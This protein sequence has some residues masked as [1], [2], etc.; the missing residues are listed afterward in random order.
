MIDSIQTATVDD[1]DGAAGSV[2]QVRESTLRLMDLAKG[3]G[4]AVIL[5]GHVTKDGSIAGPKTLEHLVDA[6][7]NLEGERYAALRLLRA[8]KNRFGSTD[9]I[10]V[11]EMAESGLLE[12]A[13]PARAFLADHGGSA[14]GSVVA[15]TL[16][17]SRPLLVEVQA[18]VSPTGYGTPSRKASGLDPNRLSLLIAVLGRRAGIALGS[19]DV[20]A[21]LAGGLSVA[22]P[23][24]DLPLALALASSARDR[25]IPPGAWRSE[26]SVSWGSCGSSSG[27]SGDCARPPDSASGCD[28]A[29]PR[30]RCNAAQDRGARGL[31][32]GHASGRHRDR[33]VRSPDA[34]WRGAPRDA[35]LTVRRGRSRPGT[36]KLPRELLIRYI[37]VLGAALG[38]AIGLALATS[39]GGLFSGS[40]YAGAFL[41]AWVVAWIVVGFAIL[42]YLTVVPATWLIRRVEELST[43]EFVAAVIGLLLGLLMGL[44]LGVPLSGLEGPVGTWLPLGIS[45]FMGL[46]MLGLTVAKRKDLLIA[47]EAVGILRP[48]NTDR[49]YGLARGEPRIVVDTSAIIDGRIAEIVESGFIYGTLVIPRFVLDELQHIADSSDA[50]RRNRGRRGLDILNRM[51]KEPG[52]PVE[53]VEDDVPEIAEVDAKLVALALARS[54]VILTNDFNLNRVAELQGVRVMNINSLANAVKPAV[55]PGEELRVRVIQEG[56]EAGQGVAFLDDGTMIVIEGGAR[57]IDRDLDVSVT[58]VLQTVA[59]RMIFAQP[60]LD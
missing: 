55:L 51:Q 52:T 26:R 46:G 21:N 56:K 33:P 42:P 22:E 18:L 34:S 1:L 40:A 32:R 31:P 12:V 48:P 35:R 36:P 11:F 53:I 59:G 57:H 17:G 14:P 8:T 29:T 20:Y 25:A 43:A 16:E 19:H 45:I 37:R 23:A 49:A 7:I 24:L 6:V 38:G 41:A 50:L 44:L 9:E 4:I 28:R 3:D 15:P 60:R 27:S 47:A 39:G 54:R 10:G 5:V 2:G 13:D 58:R 30:S